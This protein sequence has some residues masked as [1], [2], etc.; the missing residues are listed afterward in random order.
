MAHRQK[1]LALVLLQV[2]WKQKLGPRGGRDQG[3]GAVGNKAAE[4]Q[5]TRQRGGS[6]GQEPTTRQPPLPYP[7]AQVGCYAY[8]KVC[9]TRKGK[10]K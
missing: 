6:T 2:Y 9:G 1:D 10:L 8:V 3:R 4:R 5:G 7:G